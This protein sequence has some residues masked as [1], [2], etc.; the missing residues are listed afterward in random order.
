MAKKF[1]VFPALEIH[2]YSIQFDLQ[3]KWKICLMKYL[4][5]RCKVDLAILENLEFLS[6]GKALDFSS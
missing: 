2:Q 1:V 5:L 6:S 3:G 4:L